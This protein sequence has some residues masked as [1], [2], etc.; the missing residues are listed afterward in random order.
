MIFGGK[1]ESLKVRKEEHIGKARTIQFFKVMLFLE[2]TPIEFIIFLKIVILHNFSINIIIL[3][4]LG[5][6][7]FLCQHLLEKLELGIW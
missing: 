6:S 5:I 4:N 7:L 1:N 2:Y 3:L